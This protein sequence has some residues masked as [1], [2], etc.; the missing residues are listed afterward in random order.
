VGFFS[1][2]GCCDLEVGESVSNRAEEARI[3]KCGF[4]CL[5]SG[6]NIDHEY[7]KRVQTTGESGE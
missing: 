1:C 4:R 2:A 3:K 7:L 6:W 5:N